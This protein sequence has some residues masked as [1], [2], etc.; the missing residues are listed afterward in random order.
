MQLVDRNLCNYNESHISLAEKIRRRV[1]VFK[2]PTE[3]L[4]RTCFLLVFTTYG[5][6][7][8]K[9]KVINRNDDECWI[10]FDSEVFDTPGMLILAATFLDP[11][12]T[13]CRPIKVYPSG[14]QID[15]NTTA[16]IHYRLSFQL[17]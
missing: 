7:E 16:R 2:L 9:V 15:E 1:E 13:Y 6:F 3:E 11:A 8:S 4:E 12:G 5:A 10:D 14:I 17:T